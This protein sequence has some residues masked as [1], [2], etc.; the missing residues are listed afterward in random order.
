MTQRHV[1]H[2]ELVF[3]SSH[4]FHKT[5]QD[6]EIL[7]SPDSQIPPG[8]WVNSILQLSVR[9]YCNSKFPFKRWSS[10][11]LSKKMMGVQMAG[12]QASRYPDIQASSAGASL[13]D[14]I[15]FNSIAIIDVLSCPKLSNFVPPEVGRCL[16]GNCQFE[17][18]N[19]GATTC[20]ALKSCW[21]ISAAKCF[22]LMG[23]DHGRTTTLEAGIWYD[24]M[25]VKCCEFELLGD[26]F[27]A[28][29]MCWLKVYY[30]VA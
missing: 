1:V 18:S 2:L 7:G 13:E 12:W 8:S 21:A 6:L 27:F 11:S 23:G 3:C 29:G 16:K 24:L 22:S 26:L 5:V 17:R 10:S 19:C 9:I 14:L 20:G 15:L 30:K 25:V 4:W 28:S